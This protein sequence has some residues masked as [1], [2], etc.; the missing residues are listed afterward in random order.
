M[1]QT[2]ISVLLLLSILSFTGIQAQKIQTRVGL[3]LF[4][5]LLSKTAEGTVE[6]TKG[7]TTLN[8]NVGNT[9]GTTNIGGNLPTDCNCRLDNPVTS[10]AFFKIGAKYDVLRRFDARS[11][12]GLLVGA[13]LIGSQYN[14]TGTQVLI[15]YPFAGGTT[16]TKTD[17]TAKGFQMGAAINLVFNARIT[18]KIDV[19]FGLQLPIWQQTR[20]DYLLNKEFNYQPGIGANVFKNTVMQGMVTVKYRISNP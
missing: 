18:Y 12:V 17:K 4:P 6:F 8:V 14:Q 5:L 7:L 9:F 20:T 2:R 10:G 13:S 19:D 3:N 1:M 15:S 11:K 16:E